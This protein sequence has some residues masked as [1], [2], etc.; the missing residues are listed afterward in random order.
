MKFFKRTIGDEQSEIESFS[1]AMLH[2]SLSYASF[3]NSALAY[4]KIW[5]GWFGIRTFITYPIA[6]AAFMLYPKFF[7]TAIQNR[8]KIIIPTK[9]NGGTRP[10]YKYNPLKLIHTPERKSKEELSKLSWKSALIAIDEWEKRIIPVEEKI[11]KIV[12]QKALIAFSDYAKNDK[13]LTKVYKENGIT[14]LTDKTLKQLSL[15]SRTFFTAYYTDL[16]EKSMKVY[17]QNLVVKSYAKTNL[18]IIKDANKLSENLEDT[19][20]AIIEN[21]TKLGEEV[22]DQNLSLEEL[23]ELTLNNFEN[24]D[25]DLETAEKTVNFAINQ[26]NP[27]EHAEK[28]ASNLLSP[29]AIK[30]NTKNRVLRR[31]DPKQNMPIARM[32]TVY[33]LMDNPKAMSRAI[34]VMIVSN[35]I[36]KPI[37]LALTFYFLA[38]LD[39]DNPFL[40]PI[41]DEMFSEDS[42]FHLSKYI[43]G[44]GFIYGTAFSILSQSWGNLQM[45]ELNND[46]F[47]R[48]P[49]GADKRKSFTNFFF[50]K[51][52]IDPNNSFKRNY[53][54]NMMISIS[55]L[56]AALIT[57]LSADLLIF[58]RFELDLYFLGYFTLF[59]VPISF[60][61]NKLE[62]ALELSQ[63]YHA[64][65]A[66]ESLR[67]STRVQKMLLE[68][69]F[70]SR[71]KFNLLY[72][73]FI[74]NPVGNFLGNFYNLTLP[75]LG[76]R[77]FNRIVLFGYS[78]TELVELASQ[79]LSATVDFI[80]GAEKTI[81][82]CK[83]F[84][85]NNYTSWSKI[86]PK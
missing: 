48:I 42:F 47:D 15:K 76:Q 81:N 4:T 12:Y 16:Y 46:N 66:P 69:S 71:V 28:V 65:Y 59:F 75:E 30:L 54:H 49:E 20:A 7:K 68:K 38:G 17:L 72:R 50:K 61:F 33:A 62:N 36:D 37:E 6:C 13:E 1:R 24:I 74:E 80:P 83:K 85:T 73:P 82:V 31:L 14:N 67:S 2:F 29:T 19:I 34:R 57:Y 18:E 21:S 40:N 9:L 44:Y 35:L 60:F 25:I 27:Y 58:Q 84:F 26:E 45:F 43:F 39:K 22:S 78:P 5:Q 10:I 63:S 41:H 11:Q 79:K 70:M 56:R 55:N 77:A 52:F 64:R 51:L 53:I 8:G 86:K 3:N 23:K 32:Q